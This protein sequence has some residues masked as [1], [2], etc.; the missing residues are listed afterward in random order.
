L[1][2]KYDVFIVYSALEQAVKMAERYL[3]DKFLP[4][5]AIELLEKAL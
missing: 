5:K 2:A 1:E 3:H 4:L